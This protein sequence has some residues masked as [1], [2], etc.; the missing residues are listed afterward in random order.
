MVPVQILCPGKA[1]HDHARARR[2]QAT[3]GQR[4]LD[5]LPEPRVHPHQHLARCQRIRAPFRDAV[6]RVG[7]PGE[8]IL[9]AAI[10]QDCEGV[11]GRYIH[12]DMLLGPNP[13]AL[14]DARVARLM[15]ISR[16][17]AGLA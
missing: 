2:G 7:S 11:S 15:D 12:E 1:L 17:M 13:L 10:G 5:E 8:R 9:A 16:R 6:R 14:D 4:G 3:G